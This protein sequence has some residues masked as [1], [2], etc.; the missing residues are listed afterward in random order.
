MTPTPVPNGSP[1][2]GAPPI[3]L[4]RSLH[5]DA[6]FASFAALSDIPEHPGEITATREAWTRITTALRHQ[7]I[8]A[9]LSFHT[10]RLWYG[11]PEFGLSRIG[12]FIV[13]RLRD[14]VPD[15]TTILAMPGAR[16]SRPV[17]T[18]STPPTATRAGCPGTTAASPSA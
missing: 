9:E 5:A 16:T 13:I 14:H 10:M 12:G 8:T 3:T 7:A 1:E 4:A 11:D 15:H 17:A 6:P 18:S 2:G